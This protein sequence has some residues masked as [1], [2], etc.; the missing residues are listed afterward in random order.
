MEWSKEQVE[1][2]DSLFAIVAPLK[3]E[4]DLHG[5]DTCCDEIE[6][7]RVFQLCMFDN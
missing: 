4:L 2:I 1:F 6:F 5:D 3:D 7:E